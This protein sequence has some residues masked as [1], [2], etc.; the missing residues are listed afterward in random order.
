[1]DKK[2]IISTVAV[3]SL[4]ILIPVVTGI[5]QRQ[6]FEIRISA[7]E[8]DTP[9]NVIITDVKSDSFKVGWLTE[10][11]VIGGVMLSDGMKFLDSEK[12][13]Y[14]LLEIN[15]LNPG[16]NY[17][18]ILLSGDKE[19]TDNGQQYSIKTSNFK[20]SEGYFLVYGQVF[21]TNGYSFQQN[22]IISLRLTRGDKKSQ[23]LSTKINESGGFQIN[24][25]GLLNEELNSLFPYDNDN[26]AILTVYTSFEA[27]GIEKRYPVNFSFNR[28]F[29][30]VY[31]GEVNI[32]I[33]PAIEGD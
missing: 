5:L 22:G 8:D 18:F 21:N 14:H 9:R 16:Q 15:G 7:L 32:D 2:K 6:N 11:R 4:L 12:T 30:N 25:Y 1:M 24:L 28:Q 27:P 13:S 10:R 20:I 17:R 19:F 33:I 26:T 29:P 31:L 3:F 23:V